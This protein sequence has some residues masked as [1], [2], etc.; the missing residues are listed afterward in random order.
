VIHVILGVDNKKLMFNFSFKTQAATHISPTLNRRNLVIP[1]IGS[2]STMNKIKTLKLA[3]IIVSSLMLS[4]HVQSAELES[5]GNA[6]AASPSGKS[7]PADAACSSAVGA[8][9][10]EHKVEATFADMRADEKKHQAEVER[11]AQARAKAQSWSDEKKGKVWVQL[12]GSPKFTAFQ[13]E[14]QPYMDDLMRILGS[15]P[16]NRQEEC[17]LVQRIAAMLPAIKAIN[18]RQYALMAD[19]IRA[20]K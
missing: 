2:H 7:Q 5:A 14:K 18:A 11:V 8:K 20:A 16:K 10:V 17:Q 9:G 1:T 13:R 19:E 15:K 12:L 3:A 4:H 6:L